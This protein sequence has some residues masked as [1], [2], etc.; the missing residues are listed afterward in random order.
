V[1]ITVK[2]AMEVLKKAMQD[3]PEYA[4]TW[5]CNL[6]MSFSDALPETKYP[7][8]QARLHEIRNDGAS[9]FMKICFDVETKN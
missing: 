6:A 3:D 4:H 5:H 8:V 9:R 1:S 2:E 7:N